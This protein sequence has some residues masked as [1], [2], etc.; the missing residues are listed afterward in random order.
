MKINNALT[1]DKY[2]LAIGVLQFVLLFALTQSSVAQTPMPNIVVFLADDMGLGDTSTYQD[3]TGNPNNVQVSTPNMTRLALAGTRFTD[4][5]SGSSLCTPTRLSLLT[6]THPFRSQLKQ[7]VSFEGQ[8]SIGTLLPGTRR[9]FAHLLQDAGYG[10]YGI[11]KWHVGLNADF[12]SHD[13]YEGPLQSG[14]D[15]YTGTP[16][17]FPGNLGLIQDNELMTYDS[18]FNVVPYDAPGSMNW[19]PDNNPEITRNIQRTNLT[20]AQQY[21][22]DHVSNEPSNP[23]LLYYASHSNHTPYIGPPTLNGVTVDGFTVAGTYLSVPTTT[24][25][26]GNIIPTGSDYG[27]V[28]LERHWIPF[29]TTDSNGNV[30]AHG[31]GERAG[32]VDENDI[33]LGQLLDYLEQT[34]DPRNPGHKLVD[35]TLVIFASDNGSDLT[36]EPSVGALPQSADGLIANIRGKK[37]TPWEGGTRVPFIASWGDRIQQGHTSAATFGLNDLY[38]TFAAIV[39]RDLAAN[40]AVDSEN[41]LDALTG[42]QADDARPSML[43]YKTRHNLNIRDGQLKLIARDGD[44]NDPNLSD[45]FDGNLDFANLFSHRLFDLSNDL[46]ENVNLLNNSVY[47]ATAAEMLGT[48]QG[49]V[50]QGYSRNG[51]DAVSNGKNFQGGGSILSPNNYA[52]Y[53][54]GTEFEASV[55]TSS[56]PNFVFQAGNVS[57]RV[58]GAWIVQGNGTVTFDGAQAGLEQGSAYELRG[59]TLAS[60]STWFQINNGSRLTVRGGTADLTGQVLRF[61]ATDGLVEI[62][63]GNILARRL[64]FSDFASTIEGSKV[65]R[66]L[67]GQESSLALTSTQDAVRFGDDGNLSNDYIDFESGSLGRLISTHDTPFFASLFDSGQLRVNGL[68]S[69]S[70]SL[71][72]AD[73]FAV[74]QIG[75]GLSSLTLAS[76]SSKVGDFDRDGDV[77]ADDIDFFVGNVNADASG[78]LEQLDFDADGTVSIADL[79]FHITVLAEPS[80][81]AQGALIGD[82]NLDGRVDVLGDAFILVSNLSSTGPISY[83]QGN[84]NADLA[85]DVLNDAFALV[86]SLGQ[87]NDPAAAVVQ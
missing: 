32:R 31:P 74:N 77:D 36:S 43:V 34:D 64:A 46:R 70:L 59:G 69:S 10:T 25:V 47:A 2:T 48:L 54:D 83:S 3:L 16:G 68:A 19:D 1:C 8:D 12:N 85:V 38:A 82:L 75:G 86:S 33:A 55:L 51:A 28:D 20:A 87:N 71:D 72:F 26:A 50:N 67:A 21:L 62:S 79:N 57:Q 65:L 60:T 4:V 42:A 5:Q 61:H 37:A 44:Y 39:N 84:I 49:Y 35:N 56:A 18:N 23:F 9:T 15:R 63:G 78:E 22:S 30:I 53:G 45:R 27:D 14:F 80:N 29:L 58:V 40:E 11:G 7:N 81:G 17:N 73:Y 24:D 76:A 66:F 6:G 41:I 52:Y 13:I